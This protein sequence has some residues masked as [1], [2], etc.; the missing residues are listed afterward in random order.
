MTSPK[1]SIIV[2][3]GASGI[4]LA[5]SR[6]FAS[7]GHRVAMLDISAATGPG[8]AAEVAAEHPQ[9]IVSFKKCD[10]S[11]WDE[12]AAVF[13]EVFH[14]HGDRLDYVM[15]NAGL[16]GGKDTII[17]LDEETPQPPNLIA[18]NV[19]LIGVIYSIKLASYYLNKEK[20]GEGP[21]SKGGSI[22]C[23]A[24][25][26]GFYPFPVAPLYA[27]S[28]AGVISL[29]RSTERKLGKA[30]ITINGLAPAIINTNIAPD[31]TLFEHMIET[32]MSTLIR[33]VGELLADRSVTGQVAEIHGDSVTIRPHLDYVDE[34]SAKNMETFWRLG[35]V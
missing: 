3:G 29:V 14:E 1:K 11:S 17:D 28:K 31:K 21:G 8:L 34:D 35:G 24:S 2:T 6:H 9:A 4:G 32:P 7:Q 22:I 33:G 5:M 27:A 23:T 19:N 20:P 30:N 16:S 15:A 18:I 26:S 13:K 25:N 12:Q 10:V